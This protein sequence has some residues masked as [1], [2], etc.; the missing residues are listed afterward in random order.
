MNTVV[1]GLDTDGEKFVFIFTE[2][3]KRRVVQAKERLEG[4]NYYTMTKKV[5]GQCI[6]L[7]NMSKYCY[8]ES[9]RFRHVFEQLHF[10]VDGLDYNWDAK[11]IEQNLTEKAKKVPLNSDA[12][13][14]SIAN[15]FSD[16]NCH[17]LKGI[18]KIMFFVCCR[19]PPPTFNAESNSAWIEPDTDVQARDVMVDNSHL[20]NLQSV[21]K[22]WIDDNRDTFIGYSCAQGYQTWTQYGIS[23]FGHSLTHMIAKYACEEPLTNI[24]T[25][26]CNYMQTHFDESGCYAPVPGTP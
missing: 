22:T 7:N 12:F 13:A 9:E 14:L 21:D 4:S 15:I 17:R 5:R 3:T 23:R 10:K 6:I 8:I 26:T 18:P 24:M 19:E 20:S 11:E 1:K 2:F 16:I 25:R